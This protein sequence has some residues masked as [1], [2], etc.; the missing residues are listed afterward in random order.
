MSMPSRSTS[1][2]KT[3]RSGTTVVPAGTG[4]ASTAPLSTTSAQGRVPNTF[5]C[6]RGVH[7]HLPVDVEKPVE[8]GL[9]AVVLDDAGAGTQ[10]ERA[11]QVLVVAQ[12]V[13]RIA[14]LRVER[15]SWDAHSGVVARRAPLPPLRGHH[16][17]SPPHPP[18][19][20]QRQPP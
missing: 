2:P 9:Q 10:A 15:S 19:H 3:M 16:P 7:A 4:S 11:A 17:P 13:E 1:W 20:P 8:V 18:H 12:H 14:Q 5:S 6:R